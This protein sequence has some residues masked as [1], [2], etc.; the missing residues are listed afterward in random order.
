M[1]DIFLGLWNRPERFDPARGSLRNF[2]LTQSDSRAIDAVRSR[3][4]R[5]VREAL[6]SHG[7][8][9][10][11]YD[12]Q[13]AVWDLVLAQQI[14]QALRRL[15]DEERRAIELAYF[16]DHSY[17]VVAEILDQPEDTVKS[18]I[19]TGMRKMRAILLDAGIDGAGR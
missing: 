2:L 1:Q 18:R 15:P 13:Y 17:V 16:E 4:A 11:S 7:S 3:S 12:V 6:D 8:R 10:S 9:S 19:R 14:A 5:R